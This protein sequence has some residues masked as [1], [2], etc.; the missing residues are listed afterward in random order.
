MALVVKQDELPSPIPIGILGTAAEMPTTAD[1][2]QLVE[3][4]GAAGGVLTP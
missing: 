1:N 3:Q 2:G 4:A